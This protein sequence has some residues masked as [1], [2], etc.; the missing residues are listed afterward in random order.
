M[1]QLSCGKQLFEKT[2]CTLIRLYDYI[3]NDKYNLITKHSE[4]I[5]IDL[6]YNRYFNNYIKLINDKYD[7]T[8]VNNKKVFLKYFFND[9]FMPSRARI[10]N[11]V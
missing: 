5:K 11:K 2:R 10:Y 6:R 9:T 3:L 4:T 7:R 8:T 1:N